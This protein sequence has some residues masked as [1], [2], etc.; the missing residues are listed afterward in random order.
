MKLARIQHIPSYVQALRQQ[1]GLYLG[2]IIPPSFA[3]EAYE[4]LQQDPTVQHSLNYLSLLAAGRDWYLETQGK[5]Y[6]G[7]ARCIEDGLKMLFDFTHARKS[8]ASGILFGLSLLK[9]EWVQEECVLGGI[10]GKWWICK[11]LKEVDPRRIRIEREIENRNNC[12][13]TIWSPKYDRFVVIGDKNKSRENKYRKKLKER[14]GE[15]KE[16]DC[17]YNVQDYIWFFSDFSEE[18]AGYGLGLGHI[19]WSICYIKSKVLQYRAE[20][21][22]TWARPWLIGKLD[23]AQ[24]VL[25][26][27]TMGTGYSSITDRISTVLDTLDKMRGRHVLVMGNEDNLEVKEA[28]AGSDNMMNSFLEYLDRQITTLILGSTLSTMPN[29]GTGSFSQAKVHETSTDAVVAYHR[30]RIEEVLT[31]DLIQDFVQRNRLLLLRKGLP[32][33]GQIQ[34]K[35]KDP[36]Q[37]QQK[38]QIKQQSL[39]LAVQIGLPLKKAEVYETLGFSVPTDTDE[40][41]TPTQQPGRGQEQPGA[42][43]LP[44]QTPFS[45]N[46]G[47]REK[48]F[49]RLLK[50]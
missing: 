31:R 21:A 3:Q 37:N 33:R 44:F 32:S 27:M 48:K 24:G 10:K 42:G 45:F 17:E 46:V 47:K 23:L 39:P 11:E 22:E 34:F 13:W 4:A 25:T 2:Y 20:L 15:E 18:M 40:L 16:E 38:L 29:Q 50:N 49:K 7:T 30:E 8:M 12:Y 28:G 35:I 36:R 14:M 6:D 26:D 5:E 9:K 1:I 43:G 19:L 41:F